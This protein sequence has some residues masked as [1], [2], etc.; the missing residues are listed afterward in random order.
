MLINNKVINFILLIYI[1][2]ILLLLFLAKIK[3]V[4]MKFSMLEQKYLLLNVI[5]KFYIKL[6]INGPQIHQLKFFVTIF[7]HPQNFNLNFI[8]I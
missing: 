2:I 1:I 7:L 8:K 3:G 6:P 5:S 4:G